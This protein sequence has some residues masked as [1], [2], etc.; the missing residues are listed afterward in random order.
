M[1]KPPLRERR[2]VDELRPLDLDSLLAIDH[3]ARVI[4]RYVEQRDLRVLE[5][6]IKA[7]AHT[8]GR[9]P[10]SSRLVLAL[11]LYAMNRGVYN[12]R[13]PLF[14]RVMATIRIAGRAA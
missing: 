12:T 2:Q 5:E 3:P 11:W 6:A 13:A 4:W 9:A 14:G 8:P 7:R 10:A 1:G